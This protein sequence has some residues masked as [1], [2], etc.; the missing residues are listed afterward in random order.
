MSIL[1]LKVKDAD[2]T[3]KAETSNDNFVNL[4]FNGEYTVGDSIS[5]DISEGGRY[6]L[7]QL[8]DVMNTSFVYMKK[9][10]YTF[11]IPFNEMLIAYNPKSFTGDVHLLKA[12]FA[13]ETEIAA[14]KNLAVNEYDNHENTCC[15]PHAYANVETRGES[16]FAA[17]NAIDGNVENHS[18][19]CWPYESW[20]INMNPEAEITVDFGRTVEIDEIILFTRAD[21]PHDSWWEQCT[22]TFSDGCQK[23]VSMQK[24]DKPH[25]FHIEKKKINWLKLGKLIKDKNDPSPFPALSQIEVYGTETI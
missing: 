7:I 15:Y 19:G 22:F 8:D 25:V 14:Y 1:F 13:T 20:G 24:S 11:L 4:V 2:G 18:H 12:R 17:R 9:T 10:T 21:F 3:I 16:V 6:L 23:T 5:I